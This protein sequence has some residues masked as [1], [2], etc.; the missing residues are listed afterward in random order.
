[1]VEYVS[2]FGAASAQRRTRALVVD[3]LEPATH[4]DRLMGMRRIVMMFA[5]VSLFV[6]LGVLSDVGPAMA[7][8]CASPPPVAAVAFEGRV[9]EHPEGTEIFRFDVDKVRF[10]AAVDGIVV[11]ITHNHERGDVREVN[12]CAA[13]EEPLAVGSRLAVEAYD[14][15]GEATRTLFANLCGGKVNILTAVSSVDDVGRVRLSSPRCQLQPPRA[16]RTAV[17]SREV[18]SWSVAW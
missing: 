11:H 5:L 7:C 1:M 9:T 17:W 10:G 6:G 8:S 18:R 13:L 16:I 3:R 15:K 4:G 2:L 14:A 12:T